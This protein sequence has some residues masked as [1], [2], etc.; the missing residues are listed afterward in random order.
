MEKIVGII[1]ASGYSK[2]MGENKLL[3]PY[4]QSCIVE[5]I[6]KEIKKVKQFYK[7]ILVAKDEQVL[8][9]GQK[10]NIKVVKNDL[11]YLGKSSSIHIG[12]N[13]CNAD[14]YMFFMADQPFIKKETIVKLINEAEKNKIIVPNYKGVKGSPCIFHKKY[15]KQLLSLKKEQ[16]GGYIIKNNKDIVKEITIQDDLQLV[17]IDTK[18]IYSEYVT[19][20]NDIK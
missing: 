12:I 6:I 9:I 18:K 8:N 2:R 15:K 1:L 5:E 17:D 16:G 20:E 4:L 10:H 19:K 3:L 7:I 14:Y 13:S 11:S